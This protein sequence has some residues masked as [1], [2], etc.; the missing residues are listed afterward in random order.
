MYAISVKTTSKTLERNRH[1]SDICNVL[2]RAHA[3]LLPTKSW[4]ITSIENNLPFRIIC[5][6]WNPT[7]CLPLYTHNCYRR[8]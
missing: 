7:L 5:F 8:K 1:I 6:K 4:T 3:R 2:K